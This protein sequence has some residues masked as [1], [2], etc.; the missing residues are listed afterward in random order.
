MIT[1]DPTVFSSPKTIIPGVQLELN[2]GGAIMIIGP[3]KPLTINGGG[4]GRV[5]QVDK[6]VA[7]SI[8]GLTITKG[9]VTGATPSNGGG[10]LNYGTTTLTN[11]TISSSTGA[12][13]GGLDND[14]GTATLDG[15]TVSANFG[16]FGGGLANTS[17]TMIVTNC[18][19]DGGNFG[20]SG[21]ALAN[22]GTAILTNCT[23][24]GNAPGIT[25]GGVYNTATLTLTDCTI[26]KNLAQYGGG[27]YNQSGTATLTNTIVANNT[28]SIGV[29]GPSDIS[30]PAK[31][32]GSFNLI[33]IGGSGGLTNGANGNIVLTTLKDLGLAPL[34]NYGGPTL[35]MALLPGSAAIGK[36]TAVK[37]ITTDQ[38]GVVRPD[39]SVD[40]GA[41][42]DRGFTMKVVAGSSPQST[43]RDREFANPLA[44]VVTSPFGDPV[45]G[46]VVTFTAPS[47]GAS[48][49][50]IALTATIGSD[51]Q[52]SVR[53]KANDKR[54]DY[55][56]TASA[57][58]AK[59][60]AGFSLRNL[61]KLT[62]R[63]R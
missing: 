29:G 12:D 5:F 20:T 16:T 50:L 48:A 57:A 42:Q 8:S 49:K 21:C 44:V 31:V 63:A 54:G 13:G 9:D 4:N 51:G 15:C 59:Q 14:G 24:G 32:S 25:G 39:G 30:G 62:A 17:G 34:G 38:R 27:L 23:I 7:A 22:S 60:P 47:D 18:T 19:I 28:I 3:A 52:A 26:S 10:L 36:G 40:I 37:G 45:A 41:F 2:N 46:G 1:F 55:I 58:G 6:G 61:D 11:C 43:T 53:A 35:T 56:V 33:G